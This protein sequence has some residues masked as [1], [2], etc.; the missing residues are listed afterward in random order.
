MKKAVIWYDSE[1]SKFRVATGRNQK[2]HIGR[3]NTKEE[4]I[5]AKR[6][7]DIAYTAGIKDTL[8]SMKY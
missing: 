7:A 2:L 6:V 3:Y 5:E 8:D 1:R 4:A